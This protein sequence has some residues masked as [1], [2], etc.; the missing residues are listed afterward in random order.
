MATIAQQLESYR[1]ALATAQSR[2]DTAVARKLEQ[3]IADLE[4]FQARHPDVEEAP[5]PLEVFCDLNPSDINCL[6]YDD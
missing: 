3:Q 2:G 4:G 6:V 1:E 5:S